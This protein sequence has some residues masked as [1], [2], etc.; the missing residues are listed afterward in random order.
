MR[1]TVAK[2]LGTCFGVQDAID[3]ALDESYRGELTVIG[4]L[5]HNP[6]T[7]ERLRQN[8]VHIVDRLRPGEIQT[9][10]VMI[11]AHGAPES[12]RHRAES[13]GYRVI[14]ASCPLVLRVHRAMAELVRSG[15]HPVVIGQ[16]EHVE[17][18]G[19]IGDL[20]DYTVIRDETEIPKLAGRNKIG[21]VSQTTQQID[22][23]LR[24][25]E[26]IR[27]AYPTAQVEF[28]D[29]VCKPTKDRQVAV[30]DLAKQVDLMIVIG[31]FN[32]S[33]TKKL[34][35]VCD[36][37]GV[38]AF[39]IERAAELTPEMFRGHEHVG[40]TAG[41]STP[42]EVIEEVYYAILNMPDVD[43]AACS[44]LPEREKNLY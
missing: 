1:V 38:K 13:L 35:L 32:S 10:N 8:G 31:G 37:L 34:K 42:H 6:Q 44:G 43:R 11:T 27:A 16:A 29:T 21:I 39:H 12:L 25:V 24:L 26:K 18:K 28:H 33:N 3:L 5:V 2:A 7:V 36:E 20:K 19:I 22:F 9:K 14:D 15:F 17:V 4:Q 41:T 30:R 40:I 23:V